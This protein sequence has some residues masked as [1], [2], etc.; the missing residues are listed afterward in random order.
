MNERILLFDGVCNLCNGVVKFIIPRDPEAIF[1]FAA[2]QSAAGQALLVQYG[3]PVEGFESF[4][5]IRDGRAYQRSTAA[6]HVLRDM[7]G[8]WKLF[9]VFIIIPRPVRD[10]MYDLIA[11]SRYSIFGRTD[12]CMVPTPEVKGRFIG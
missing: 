7:R 12:A 6:L 2:L 5:Y 11:R 4:V 1:R 9:Y 8:A 10:W 3:L